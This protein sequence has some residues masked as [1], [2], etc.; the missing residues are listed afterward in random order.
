MFSDL[1]F[2]TVME[3]YA[4]GLSGNGDDSASIINVDST[5]TYTMRLCCR[6][7]PTSY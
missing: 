2:N 7:L 6:H 5:L 4:C 1:I 3:F